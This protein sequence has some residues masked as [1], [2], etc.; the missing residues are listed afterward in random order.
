[1]IRNVINPSDLLTLM[2]NKIDRDVKT[3]LVNAIAIVREHSTVEQ[4]IAWK[5]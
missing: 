5:P 1:M 3:I 2:D 4:P